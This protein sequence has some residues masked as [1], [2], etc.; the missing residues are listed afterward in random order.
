MALRGRRHFAQHSLEAAWIQV[1]ILQRRDRLLETQ[2]ELVAIGKTETQFF[3]RKCT[4]WNRHFRLSDE[5][6]VS[7]RGIGSPCCKY[8][9]VAPIDRSSAGY[10]R[11]RQ[12]APLEAGETCQ[13]S[14]WQH[15][16]VLSCLGSDG[17]CSHCKHSRICRRSTGQVEGSFVQEKAERLDGRRFRRHCDHVAGR[18]F[19]AGSCASRVQLLK[20]AG[21]PVPCLGAGHHNRVWLCREFA[22]R[23]TSSRAGLQCCPGPEVILRLQPDRATPQGRHSSLLPH[24]LHIRAVPP[25]SL[26]FRDLRDHGRDRCACVH[27]NYDCSE[28]GLPD[29]RKPLLR[30]GPACWCLPR[31]NFADICC[32][33]LAALRP[34][35]TTA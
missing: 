1:C 16:H 13:G 35:T 6:A 34:R 29:S 15:C 18:R 33:F 23:R 4:R 12:A 7:W 22:Y 25:H 32:T 8:S 19:R 5:H 10:R 28:G 27:C 2:R 31:F 17:V 20:A 26:G 9:V 14:V 24:V 30:R 3:S 21:D 11:T